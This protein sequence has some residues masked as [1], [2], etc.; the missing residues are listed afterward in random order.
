LG[1]K[2]VKI[3]NTLKTSASPK[4]KDTRREK[5]GG[6]VSVSQPSGVHDEV[7][8]S[9]DATRLRELEAHLAGLDVADPKKVESIRQAIA[10]G[11]F[12]VDEEAVA[13]GLIKETIDHLSSQGKR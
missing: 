13:D 7:K 1:K 11:T 6:S 3:D 5:S 8:L 2:A 10:D 9:G 12:K 4:V